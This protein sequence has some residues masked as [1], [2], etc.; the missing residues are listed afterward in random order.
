MAR[1]SAAKKREIGPDYK[2]HHAGI[3]KFINSVMLD[4]KKTKAEKAVYDALEEVAKKVTTDPVEVYEKIVGNVI[5]RV[6]TRSR[7]LGGATY[8][9]PV[10]VRPSRGLC[11]A[12]RWLIND[13]R[14]RSGSSMSARLTIVFMDAYNG[15]GAAVKKR[16]DV[17]KM[18]ESNKAF[19]HIGAG[20]R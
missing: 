11:L 7:R 19:A 2:Y 6:E 3:A 20:K 18:A 15:R 5:P 17:H 14:G 16:D 4:G 8:Q 13:A 1:K 9:V 10:E 12:R